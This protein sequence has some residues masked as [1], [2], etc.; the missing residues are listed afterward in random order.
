MLRYLSLDIICS[1]IEA[2]SFRLSEQM[3]STGKY[4]SI[5]PRQMEAFVYILTFIY[6]WLFFIID[7]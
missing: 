7:P 6:F 4:P 1:L 3:M 2:H 5:F